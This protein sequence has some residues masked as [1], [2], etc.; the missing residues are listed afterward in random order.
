MASEE[1]E[2]NNSAGRIYQN[3][4]AIQSLNS[5]H[6]PISKLGEALGVDGT[7]EAIFTAI[8]DMRRD[9]EQLQEEVEEIKQV[10]DAKFALWNEQLADIKKSLY[11]FSIHPANSQ[12]TFVI[13][14]SAVVALRFIA[15]DMAKEEQATRGELE[16]I[17]EICESL[18]AEILSNDEM[19][20]PL[21][22]WLLELVRLMRDGIDRYK[23]RGSRGLQKQLHEMVGSIVTHPHNQKQAE[24]EAKTIWQRLMNGVEMM[25]KISRMA[26]TGGKGVGFVMKALENFS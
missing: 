23:I 21:K 15:A 7:W 5:A 11:A 10:N 16:Q 24:T 22:K 3:L 26:E 14:P 8:I 9:F 19:P 13:T 20:K 2:Y 1:F 12:C 18:R 6:L 17:R 4:R 25:S